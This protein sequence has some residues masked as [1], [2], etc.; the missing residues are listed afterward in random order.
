MKI[1][2][3]NLKLQTTDI[4]VYEISIFKKITQ[5]QISKTRISLEMA[6]SLSESPKN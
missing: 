6:R 3:Y 4:Q 2:G 1:S 5:V